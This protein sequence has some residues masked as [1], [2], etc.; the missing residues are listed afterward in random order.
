MKYK[1]R[2]AA[3][4][5]G[6]ESARLRLWA[7][8]FQAWLS[9]TAQPKTKSSFE[10]RLYTAHDVALLRR[11][12]E[13]REEARDFKDIAA[14]LPPPEQWKAE[15]PGEQEES[16]VLPEVA[17]APATADQLP[18][19]FELAVQSIVAAKNETIT[20]QAAHITQLE[21][22]VLRL[23]HELDALRSQA[24]APATTGSTEPAPVSQP[25]PE[26]K[27]SIWQR[28]LARLRR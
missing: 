17:T 12:K 8:T 23:Q 1:P 24:T 13:Q 22:D 20:A 21:A 10:S 18:R 4:L 28:A 7:R 11:V 15:A 6:I 3:Q 19:A 25:P 9:D 5:L 2:E 27:P 26:P 16:P 14:S